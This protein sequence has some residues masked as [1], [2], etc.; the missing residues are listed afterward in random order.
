MVS[1]SIIV[2]L[3]A[4]FLILCCVRLVYGVT[5]LLAI[6]TVSILVEI[7]MGTYQ[8]SAEGFLTLIIILAGSIFL[9]VHRESLEGVTKW[10]FI[11]FIVYCA[12]TLIAANDTANFSKKL[13][14][15]IGYFFL[16]LMVVQLSLKEQ[17]RRILIY[18]FIASILV[19]DLP[20]IYIYYI[21][22]ERYM[23]LLHGINN[24]GLTE[25]GIMSKNNFGFYCCYMV[26]LL[27]SLYAAAKSKFARILLFALFSMQAALLVLSYT[28]A[29]WAGFVAAL[30]I[31]I[32]Y[33]RN[34][35]KLLLPFVAALVI[36]A[37]LFSV[38]RYG[39]YGEIT[40][41][42]EYGFSS[43]HF[44]LAYSWPASIKAFQ[45]KPLMGWGLGN[46]LYALSRAAKLKATSHNDYL[47]VL[48]ETGII[49]L[50]LYFCLLGTLFWRTVSSI[51]SVADEP[52]RALCVAALA[53]LASF[54]VGSMGEHLLQTPGAT[55]YV[56]TILGMAHG[57]TLATKRNRELEAGQ[58]IIQYS[59]LPAAS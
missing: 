51:R 21:A 52:S 12:L 11:I 59:G 53:M 42:K 48:V 18:G 26:S 6:R 37:A 34:K 1:L 43:W 55:G 27:I 25:V 24:K 10:P 38:I 54:L 50:F 29:A 19:T 57:T 58:E 7:P 15:L 16:Y 28:R 46:D 30:L 23:K 8:Y 13:A 44:R 39:A 2:A 9:I 33:S 40:E 45:E 5:F 32:F 41:R 20:A 3:S 22:P 17:N 14:R 31:L 4:I 36:G 47:L 56:I 49:G 35:V